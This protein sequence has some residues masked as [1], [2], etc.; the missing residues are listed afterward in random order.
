M[1]HRTDQ[2]EFD[3][4]LLRRLRRRSTRPRSPKKTPYESA[5]DSVG[6]LKFL[7]DAKFSAVK[8]ICYDMV[9]QI[10]GPWVK[11]FGSLFDIYKLNVYDFLESYTS[12]TVNSEK[13]REPCLR[14]EAI[15]RT[16]I[17]DRTNTGAKA[18]VEYAP[19]NRSGIYRAYSGFNDR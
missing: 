16:F 10:S 18:S 9:K 6:S 1:S 19:A 2:V 4:G 8:R 17:A 13:Y 11:R 3:L 14:A 7:A 12:A 5:Q 15:W